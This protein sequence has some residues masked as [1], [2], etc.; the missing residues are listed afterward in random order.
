MADRYSVAVANGAAA[1]W[2]ELDEGY[3]KAVCSED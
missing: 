3:R 2:A 1:D